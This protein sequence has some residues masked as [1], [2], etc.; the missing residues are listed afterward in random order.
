MA[1]PCFD[2]MDEPEPWGEDATA[3]Q[4]DIHATDDWDALEAFAG[5]EYW[6]WKSA[7]GDNRGVSSIGDLPAT[8]TFWLGQS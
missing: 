2:A 5:P 7:L 8:H 4:G 6:M 1:T 3:W